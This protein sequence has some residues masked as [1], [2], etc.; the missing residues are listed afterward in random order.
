MANQLKMAKVHSILTLHQQG[1]SYRRIAE[2]L[3]VNRETVARYVQ[4]ASK[5]AKAPPGPQSQNRP[6]RPSG[7]RRS[8]G[9]ALPG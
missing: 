7:P 8:A 2:L 6:K 9:P 3:G 4:Q 1:H 5:P